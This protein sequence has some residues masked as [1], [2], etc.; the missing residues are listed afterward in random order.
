MEASLAERRHKLHRSLE[1][2]VIEGG[3][4]RNASDPIQTLSTVMQALVQFDAPT[5][6][7]ASLRCM[8]ACLQKALHIRCTSGDCDLLAA[9]HKML[10]HVQKQHAS[11]IANLNLMPSQICDVQRRVDELAVELEEKQLN[12]MCLSDDIALLNEES[13]QG[14]ISDDIADMQTKTSDM[15]HLLDLLKDKVNI[16]QE[17]FKQICQNREKLIDRRIQLDGSKVKKSSLYKALEPMYAIQEKERRLL[18]N[19]EKMRRSF[20]QDG[21]NAYLLSIEC[22]TETKKIQALKKLIIDITQ[23]RDKRPNWEKISSRVGYYDMPTCLELGLDESLKKFVTNEHST[24]SNVQ[25]IVEMLE[26][27]KSMEEPKKE[28]MYRLQILFSEYDKL[29]QI[30]EQ[31]IRE[32]PS[33]HHV[34]DKAIEGWQHQTFKRFDSLGNSSDVPLWL[35]AKKGELFERRL[36]EEWSHD[37]TRSIVEDVW[38]KK[39]ASK[40]ELTLASFMCK[41]SRRMFSTELRGGRG[42][43]KRRVQWCINFVHAVR[44]YAKRGDAVC[45][46]TDLIVNS[47]WC[48]DYYLYMIT[49]V[50]NLHTAF[51]RELGGYMKESMSVSSFERILRKQFL[52]YNDIEICRMLDAARRDSMFVKKVDGLLSDRVTEKKAEKKAERDGDL[53]VHSIFAIGHR[54]FHEASFGVYDQKTADL[55]DVMC[56]TSSHWPEHGG[57]GREGGRDGDGGGGVAE[58]KKNEEEEER[59]EEEKKRQEKKMSTSDSRTSREGSEK[60]GVTAKKGSS[61]NSRKKQQELLKVGKRGVAKKLSKKLSNDVEKKKEDARKKKK[62]GKEGKE[63]KEEAEKEKEEAKQM[64]IERQSKKL[65]SENLQS[66]NLQSEN[67]QSENLQSENLQSEKE[68]KEHTAKHHTHHERSFG[69]VACLCH[70]YLHKVKLFHWKMI[71]ELKVYDFSGS[72]KVLSHYVPLAIAA[73]TNGQLDA[74]AIDQL[75]STI[76]STNI[77]SDAEE[78][79]PEEE[80][81]HDPSHLID[82]KS[83]VLQCQ[84]CL[85][86]PFA[87]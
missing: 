60:D 15:H 18:K 66:E 7:V 84:H 31:R 77:P 41:Y 49:M 79:Q 35:R 22:K 50:N 10:Q 29:G 86:L 58:Q 45:S 72:G 4:K 48:N 11:N 55:L 59:Q 38:K 30:L 16:L 70:H 34:V 13:F 27:T 82:I 25:S 80:E 62:E 36:E 57:G 42:N 65:Q 61:R 44:Y 71:K 40:C 67:L 51:E 63:C 9:Q 12:T 1:L 3:T 64:K 68:K 26:E 5:E 14:P 20:Y 47:H 85:A 53:F 32:L 46:V 73:A 56:I 6:T 17:D 28:K 78:G 81:A 19:H 39:R 37:Y 54:P 69:F 33:H 76:K 87:P 74:S 8:I 23:S 52:Y 43:K 24:K 21:K 2:E 75:V 83:F